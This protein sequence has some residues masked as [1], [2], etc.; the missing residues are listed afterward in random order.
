[1]PKDFIWRGEEIIV[2]VKNDFVNT[3]VNGLNDVF[4]NGFKQT[5]LDKEILS[6]VFEPLP[7]TYISAS[8]TKCTDN[9]FIGR[10]NE[11]V[12]AETY[13]YIYLIKADNINIVSL[14]KEKGSYAMV[15]KVDPSLIVGAMP[16][17]FV[18]FALDIREKSFIKNPAYKEIFYFEEIKEVIGGG[19]SLIA[20][21]RLRINPDLLSEVY[22]RY[23]QAEEH[24]DQQ[25]SL[26]GASFF[27]NRES[28]IFP[29]SDIDKSQETYKSPH[30]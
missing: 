20:P 13:G 24:S 30:P 15:S 16:S 6:E 14:P 2:D 12:S 18:A 9:E 27:Q 1:M 5:D 17:A 25:A 8:S 7:Q 28:V 3:L 22:Q 10:D 23:L 21:E 29:R 11:L 19:I 4:Q 26:G